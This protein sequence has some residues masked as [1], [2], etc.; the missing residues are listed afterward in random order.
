[1]T[2]NKN[3]Q[4]FNS[5]TDPIPRLRPELDIIPVK[6][7]GQSY[8]YFHDLRG[9][10]TKNFVLQHQA[11]T[12]LSLLDGQKSIEDLRKYLGQDI[13]PDQL[14]DYVRFLDENRLLCSKHY[15]QHAEHIEQLY[16]EAQ[17]HKS[18][19]AGSSYPAD[20][21]ALQKYLDEAFAK[22]DYV[23]QN[24]NEKDIKALYAPHI[25]PR[26]GL[27]SYVNAFSA[28]ED[29][30]P[31]RV[32]ILATSHYGGLYP[33]QYE[34]SPFIVSRKNFELPLRTIEADQKA[35]DELLLQSSAMGISGNDRAHRIEHSIELHLLFLSYL[36][37]HN[38]QIVPILVRGFDELYYMEQG[39]LAR[40]ITQFGNYLNEQ[41]GQDKETFFLISGDL[42]HIGKKF[43]DNQPASHLFSEVKSFDRMFITYAEQGNK[44]AL[45]NL[46]KKQY[47]PYRICGFPPLYSFLSSIPNVK[48]IELSYDLWDESERESAVTF[49]S[50]LYKQLHK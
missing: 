35:I 8:L 18:V 10:A 11:G 32:I 21:E 39:H 20:P 48:G 42:A 15:K 36:W 6:N 31:G 17:V 7:N 40:Q 45:L 26:V 9:Y 38:F 28:I 3:G 33:A 44:K 30:Q 46:M 14:L 16:E 19:T 47:D 4:L 25:D 23:H 29:I 5:K 2:M 22:H 27:D 13:S 49:G 24:I 37:D 12:M 50:I 34:N 43:G 41:Y 1:M